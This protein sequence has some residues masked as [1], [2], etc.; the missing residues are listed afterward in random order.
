MEITNKKHKTNTICHWK[1]KGI[2]NENL[3]EIYETYI[4]TMNCTHCGKEFR[5]T[6]ERHLD[7]CHET[8]LF[9]KIVCHRCNVMNNYINYPAGIPSKHERKKKYR[10]NNKEKIKEYYD[11]NRDKII[12]KTKEYNEKNKEKIKEYQK[13]Y[14][15][16]NRDKIN[17]RRRE[18]RKEKKAIRINLT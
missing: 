11:N 15:V 17:E 7:H 18:L 10:E 5:N 16:K 2:I 8:G 1:H 6:K 14:S 9:R 12:E 3:E 13:E 4:K